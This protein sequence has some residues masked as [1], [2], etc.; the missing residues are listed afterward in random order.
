MNELDN[1]PS[2]GLDNLSNILIKISSD[3]T[4][5]FLCDLINMLFRE[6]VI[7]KSLAE[8][9]IIP[10]HKEGVKTD[11]NIYRPISFLSI[12]SKIFERVVYNRVYHFFKKKIQFSCKQIGFRFKHST[13]DTLVEFIEKIKL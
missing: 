1:K 11:A 13:I 6:G 12:W 9:K 8:A 10:L 5:P 7:P 2:S 3:I 4:A